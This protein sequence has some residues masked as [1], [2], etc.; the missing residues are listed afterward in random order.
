MSILH[1]CQFP[2]EKCLPRPGKKRKLFWTVVRKAS[3]LLKITDCLLTVTCYWICYVDPH[4]LR[5]GGLFSFSMFAK[6]CAKWILVYLDL[7][8][9]SKGWSTM[10]LWVGLRKQPKLRSTLFSNGSGS[11]P[12]Q[13]LSGLVESG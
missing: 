13:E 6:G 12:D 2:A 10:A 8:G 1:F 7:P 11:G 4:L 3:N 9:R 5:T